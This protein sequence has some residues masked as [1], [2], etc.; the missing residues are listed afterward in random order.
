MSLKNTLI[1]NN[2]SDTIKY[3]FSSEKNIFENKLI[4]DNPSIINRGQIVK[5]DRIEELWRNC[6]NSKIKV[7]ASEHPV[8][9]TDSVSK[10]VL[11]NYRLF[12]KYFYKEI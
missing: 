8:L 4:D 2:G 9:L 12:Y 10:T 7:I 6:F 11:K 5:W 3:G 1:I